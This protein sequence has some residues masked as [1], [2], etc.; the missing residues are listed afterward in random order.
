MWRQAG[1]PERQSWHASLPPSE[2]A[3]G[4]ELVTAIVLAYEINLPAC[5]TLS[6]FRA[7]LDRRGFSLPAAASPPAS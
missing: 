4:M 1:H 3:S 5:S 2:R 6:I 7:R